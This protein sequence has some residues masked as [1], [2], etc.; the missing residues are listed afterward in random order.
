MYFLNYI[1]ELAVFECYVWWFF[2]TLTN[3]NLITLLVIFRLADN[4]ICSGST[5]EYCLISK[6]ANSSYSTPK[7]CLVPQCSSEQI[8]S[9]TC[10]CAYPYMGT[11][12]FRAPSF[13][14]LGNS[15]TYELLHDGLKF[16]FQSNNL[17]VD[18][19]SLS[20]PTKNLDDYLLL[21]LQVFPSGQNY[22]N[23]TGVSAIGFVLSNQT[24]KPPPTFGPF[25]FIG[26]SYQYFTGSWFVAIPFFA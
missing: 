12:F 5:E 1:E 14:D 20:N 25:F 2:F 26:D 8:S 24:F 11:L 4:P 3:S 10:Q 9:P 23:H 18:S 22:F 7:N 13:S 19:V 6:K 21:S 15:T 17:P 16:S